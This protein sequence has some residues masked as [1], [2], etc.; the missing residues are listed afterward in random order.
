LTSFSTLLDP[1]RLAGEVAGGEVLE[2]EV[3]VVDVVVVAEVALE[4]CLGNP[5]SARTIPMSL[6]TTL[7]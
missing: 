3:V 6:L 1:R 2:A 7:I 5:S 4:V